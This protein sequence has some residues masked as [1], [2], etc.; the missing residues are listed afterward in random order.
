LPVRFEVT[1]PDD[2]DLRAALLAADILP[3]FS[4]AEL[5]D[6]GAVLPAMARTVEGNLAL[7]E[8]QNGGAAPSY[9]AGTDNFYAI[10]RY[11]RSSYYAMA[12]SELGAAV[13][14]AR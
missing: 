5:A 8:L 1:P 3:T 10:T 12:V 4:A 6:K 11:N 2:D 13:G 7:V 14:A 9:I